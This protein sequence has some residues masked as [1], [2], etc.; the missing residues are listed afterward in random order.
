MV[1]KV[2]TSVGIVAAATIGS[3][4]FALPYVIQASGWV[5]ALGYFVALIAVVSLP[6]FSICGRSRGGMKRSDCS[7]SPGNILAGRDSG[8]AS[9]R[10][11]SDCCLASSHILCSARSSCR[12]SFRGSRPAPRSRVFWFLLACLVWGSEGRIAWFEGVGIAL[13]SFAILFIF[14]SGHPRRGVRE[15]APR[16]VPGVIFFS[17]SALPYL[18]SPDGRASNRYTNLRMKKEIVAD[19]EIAT[20]YT[21]GPSGSLLL[22]PLSQDCS[23]GSSPPA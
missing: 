11:S 5:I 21:P 18:R 20:G 17:R 22:A 16:G 3:G 9:S 10:S 12:Y 14:F 23:T 15:R 1:R 4:V 7:A 6:T 8:L 13:V 2:F 19:G